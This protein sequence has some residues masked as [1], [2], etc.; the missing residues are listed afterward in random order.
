MPKCIEQWKRV[1]FGAYEVSNMGRVRN[2][3]TLR[4][5]KPMM[6]GRKG[7]Q[8]ETVNLAG[9]I[10]AV[11]RLVALTFHG[12]APAGRPWV[13]HRDGKRTNNSAKNLYYG[14]AKDNARDARKHH[15]HKHKLTVRQAAAVLRRRQNGESGRYLAA[16]YGV[17][18]QYICD[19]YKGRRCKR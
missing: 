2:T 9:V 14:T 18:E 13:L 16:V 3:L 11:H 15:Q 1:A 17:S 5:L 6:T 8:Y 4:M 10:I 7:M 12:E 19:I